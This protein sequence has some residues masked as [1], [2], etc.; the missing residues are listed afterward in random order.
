MLC[1]DPTKPWFYVND[2]RV[3]YANPLDSV[4]Y[5]RLLINGN[6]LK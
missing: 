6:S 5:G 2:T 4:P 3:T 1:D